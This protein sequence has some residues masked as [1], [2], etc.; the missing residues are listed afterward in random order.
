MGQYKIMDL[1]TQRIFSI[2]IR[3]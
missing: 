2:L 3:Q 1:T